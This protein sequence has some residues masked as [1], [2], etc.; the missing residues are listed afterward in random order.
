M[1]K[2]QVDSAVHVSFRFKKIRFFFFLCWC[3]CYATPSFA[4]CSSRGVLT[5]R[6]FCVEWSLSGRVAF[7]CFL[8]VLNTVLHG[9]EE[10]GTLA[11]MT[12]FEVFE[13]EKACLLAC[14]LACKLQLKVGQATVDLM[15]SDVNEA[16]L[17]GT[18]FGH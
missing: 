2:V 16:M 14:L 6:Y 1:G 13:A 18:D 9:V 11:L 15:T 17:E 8:Q 7:P 5:L 12:Y 10:Y 3:L 4:P